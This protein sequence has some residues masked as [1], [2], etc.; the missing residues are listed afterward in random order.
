MAVA[1]RYA[2]D[3][4]GNLLSGAGLTSENP[5]TSLLWR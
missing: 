2:F 1:Q 5:A 3:A 4:Y